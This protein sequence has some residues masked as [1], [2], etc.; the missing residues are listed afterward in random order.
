MIEAARR[1][2]QELDHGWIGVEH[3]LLA[4]AGGDSA[5][6]SALADVGATHAAVRTW[7]AGMKHDPDLAPPPRWSDA[8]KATPRLQRIADGL[9]DAAPE[10]WLIAI[11][12][13]PCSLA[14]SAL[15]DMAGGREPVAEALR[16]RGVDVGELPPKPSWLPHGEPIY[17]PGDR[18]MDVVRVASEEVGVGFA[19]NWIRDGRGRV[20][21]PAGVDLQAIVDRVLADA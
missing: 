4:L 12:A 15:E 17:V 7:L 2:A 20:S 14:A 5:A 19:F 18:L 10:R 6:A 13:E 11:L 9:D 16:A 8:A 3:V 1:E 21:A